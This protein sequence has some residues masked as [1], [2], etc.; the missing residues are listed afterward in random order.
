MSG[1]ALFEACVTTGCARAPWYA[2]RSPTTPIL[3]QPTAQPPQELMMW[4]MAEQREATSRLG[5]QTT[6]ITAL[7]AS[8][9][10]ALL[11]VASAGGVTV[12]AGLC[13]GCRD[14]P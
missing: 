9:D 5:P 3:N 12:Y 10:G 6:R 14:R 1:G 7:A 4:S 11:A 13:A 2:V 8:P